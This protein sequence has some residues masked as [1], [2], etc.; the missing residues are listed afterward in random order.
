MADWNA[1]NGSLAPYRVL[2][3]SLSATGLA[4]HASDGPFDVSLVANCS[5]SSGPTGNRLAKVREDTR[6]A[7]PNN[8]I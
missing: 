5:G 7:Q 6:E 1:G 4:T 3:F 8:K 2:S